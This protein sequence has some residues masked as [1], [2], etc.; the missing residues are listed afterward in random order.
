MDILKELSKFY[1]EYNGE[2]FVLGKSTLNKDIYCFKIKKTERPVIIVQYAMHAREYITSYLAIKQIEDFYKKGSNGTVYFIPAINPDGIEICLTIDRLYKANALWVDLN[3]NF[4]ARWG[5]GEKNVFFKDRENYVGEKPF[6]ETESRLLR[7]FTLFIKP[8]LTLSY[9]SKG[10][11]IYWEFF[12]EKERTERD[13]KFAKAVEICTGYKIKSVK[14]SAGG[15][16]DWCIDKLKIPALTV[17]V[18]NDGL[19]H[20][21][22][23]ENLP[24]IYEKNKDVIFAL[25][26]KELWKEN[27]WNLP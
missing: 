25:T 21:I 3:V 5:N 1:S 8:D 22:E 14:N 24:Q 16:K 11:E 27:L 12:Q 20:P 23:K 19:S 6:S 4:D 26:E 9:H 15:Y 7:D 17:E 18:G 2:K 13:F 10:E